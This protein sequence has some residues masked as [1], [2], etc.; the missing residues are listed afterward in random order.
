MDVGWRSARF[1][2]SEGGEIDG[3]RGDIL[4]VSRG[5]LRRGCSST[6]R[7]ESIRSGANPAGQS[8]GELLVSNLSRSDAGDRRD[9]T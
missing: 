9:G 8:G 6:S 5:W 1:F 4:I 2:G 7:K 3:D